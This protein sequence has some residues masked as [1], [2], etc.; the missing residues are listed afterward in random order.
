[1]AIADYL[2][3]AFENEALRGAL[4]SR[5]VLYTAMGPWSAGT[6]AAY[7]SDSV[8]NAG[9]AGQS[10]TVRGGPGALA[11]SLAS[12]A[13]AVGAT[14]RTNAEVTQILT[15][16]DRVFG[17]ALPSGEEIPARAVASA[18]DPK[19]TLTTLLDPVVIGPHLRWR[20]SNIRTPGAVSKV[21]LVLS[22]LPDF[23]GAEPDRLNGRIVI[24]PSIDY[25]EQASDAS[26]Y[27]AVSEEPFLEATIPTIDDRTLSNGSHVMSIVAQW[28]P[29]ALREGEWSVER[30]R[31]GDV[32]MKTMERY[33]PGLTELVTAR[34]VTTPIDLEERYAL[35]GGHVY[36]AEPGLD[37][38]FV[39][40]PLFGHARYRL[41]LPGLYLCGSGAHPG[42]GITGAPGANAAREILS[43]LKR[44]RR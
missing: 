14:I 18:A 39:W 43:D 5:A 40:R 25:L 34:E 7:L 10:T 36:H 44:R 20:A 23:E 42:G 28:T 41:G 9:A 12:A 21:N 32:V 22:R 27:G 2:A 11:D 17:V 30:D 3:E 4:A 24:A 13:Q 16:N 26:K 35:T 33:A 38:F 15:R 6:T 37:Q 8:G 19:R 29:Y 1:M 31:L